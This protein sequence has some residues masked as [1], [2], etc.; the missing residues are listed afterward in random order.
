M[1]SLRKLLDQKIDGSARYIKLLLS[2][3]SRSAVDSDPQD[4]ASFQATVERTVQALDEGCEEQDLLVKISA[5]VQALENYNRRATG[6]SRAY[7]QEL[8]SVLSMMADTIASLSTSSKTG[9]EQLR[10]IEKSLESAADVSDLRLLRNKLSGC[11]TLLRNESTRMRLDSEQLIK[12][13]KAAVV[14]AS[15]QTIPGTSGVPPDPVT[16]LAGPSTAQEM[17]TRMIGEGKSCTVAMFV[18]D[19]LAVLNARLGR[20]A[21][22]EA[23]CI[24]AQHLETQLADH[25]TVLRWSGPAFVLVSEQDY[26]PVDAIERRV[27]E[28]GRTRFERTVTSN[29]RSVNFNMTF[30]WTMQTVTPKDS[31]DAVC[32]RLDNFLNLQAGTH[33]RG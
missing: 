11:L 32:R 7:Q 12:S 2:G 10:N 6:K 19:T 14:R 24:A 13:L 5:V 33:P 25:G 28:V 22:D 4:L 16:G 9:V 20:A 23:L 1:V 26:A 30:S 3:I 8:R 18:L 17:I 29:H 27:K 15:I 21:G 31:A